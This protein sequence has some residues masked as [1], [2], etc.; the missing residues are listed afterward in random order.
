MLAKASAC[1]T[2]GTLVSRRIAKS[3][4]PGALVSNEKSPTPYVFFIDWHDPSFLGFRYDV[5]PNRLLIQA[6][7]PD[8]SGSFWVYSGDMIFGLGFNNVNTVS[9]FDRPT[10]TSRGMTPAVAYN[11]D[12][13]A[14]LAMAL[15]VLTVGEGEWAAIA[16]G[17]GERQL[18][19]HTYAILVTDLSIVQR[20]AIHEALSQEPWYRGARTV[21]TNNPIHRLLFG[22]VL[23]KR[24]F[25]IRDKAGYDTETYWGDPEAGSIDWLL[26]G[27]RLS[28]V[29]LDPDDRPDEVHWGAP[30]NVADKAAADLL[31]Q[32]SKTPHGQLLA[33]ALIAWAS[34]GNT[35]GQLPR[36]GALTFEVGALI[37]P[38]L[39]DLESKLVG[40]SLSETHPLGRHKARLFHSA[41]GINSSH[42][43]YLAFQLID[44]LLRSTPSQTRGRY[45]DDTGESLVQYRTDIAVMGLN[46]QTAVVATGW[47]VDHD[48]H[49]R[50]VT[51]LPK[52]GATPGPVVE[53]LSPLPFFSEN[54]ASH[55][56]AIW[57]SAVTYADSVADRYW[58]PPVDGN[59]NEIVS[60]LDRVFISVSLD[61]H[62]PFGDWLEIRGGLWSAVPDSFEVE[63][64][65]RARL[66]GIPWAHAFVRVCELNEIAAHVS[67]WEPAPDLAG[68]E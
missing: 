47:K 2:L 38:T 9:K 54:P 51:S 31:R 58:I 15:S 48:M 21:S 32:I 45:V 4:R 1:P 28:L 53:P 36:L 42:W 8:L 44:G 34:G 24:W 3:L 62:S 6:L 29:E 46:G 14:D 10:L 52:F 57:S 35:E 20:D 17:F 56:D 60:E 64:P 11:S 41:L 19:R 22:R 13:S 59:G 16:P 40:Y 12:P 5:P 23:P 49:I 27:S 30:V 33:D 37:Y 61:A 65:S 7:Q 66:R 68:R 67:Y 39:A 63:V 18:I 55:H 26:E 43:R 25:V 50:I